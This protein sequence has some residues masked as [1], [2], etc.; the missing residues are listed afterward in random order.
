MISYDRNRRMK[1]Y[2]RRVLMVE[3]AVATPHTYMSIVVCVCPYGAR[4]FLY[5]LDCDRV[6]LLRTVSFA[7]VPQQRHT[8]L[9]TRMSM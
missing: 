9:P 3:W 6:L 4:G 8:R 7:S 5:F 2:E 1:A